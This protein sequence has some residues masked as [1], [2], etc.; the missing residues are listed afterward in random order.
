MQFG[1]GF[2]PPG[3]D[4][5][6]IYRPSSDTYAAARECRLALALDSLL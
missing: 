5:D 4:E 3:N 6:C 2:D 1:I